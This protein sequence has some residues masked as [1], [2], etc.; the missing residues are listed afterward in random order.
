M[1]RYKLLK[2][3]VKSKQGEV[4]MENNHVTL[5]PKDYISE[6]NEY[7]SK[8]QVENNPEWFKYLMIY[9]SG[10]SY[11][12]ENKS[13]SN[14]EPDKDMRLECLKLACDIEKTARKNKASFDSSD[15]EVTNT[16]ESFYKFL[17]S[18]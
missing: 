5:V 16:A 17:N 15:E 9:D 14:D 7:F 8:I 6:S 10:V 2:D 18:K 13:S 3:T 12:K 1:K 4:V 11:W